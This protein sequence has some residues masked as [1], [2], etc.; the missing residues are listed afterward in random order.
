MG[1]REAYHD[2]NA[3]HSQDRA[4]SFFPIHAVILLLNVNS[5]RAAIA[6]GQAFA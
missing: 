1:R 2:S 5:E 4:I 3:D 6:A